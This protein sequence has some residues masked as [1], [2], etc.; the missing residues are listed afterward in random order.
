[1]NDLQ[2]RL[3]QVHLDFHTAPSIPDVGVDWDADEFARIVREAHIDSMTVFAKCHH[4][5]SYHPTE[6][7]VMHP[8]SSLTCWASKSRCCTASAY[9]LRFT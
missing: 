2:L 8:R 9:V 4:G 7:G 3:R 1:M 5:L 6:V